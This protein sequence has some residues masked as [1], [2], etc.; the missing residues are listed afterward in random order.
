MCPLL[1]L[2]DIGKIFYNLSNFI[3]LPL[4]LRQALILLSTLSRHM[5]NV[6]LSLFF[7]NWKISDLVYYPNTFNY[8]N[9]FF[10]SSTVHLTPDN[11]LKPV[12]HLETLDL[13]IQYGHFW[14]SDQYFIS[15]SNMGSFDFQTNA[16]SLNSSFSYMIPR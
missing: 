16:W 13:A 4:V 2:H 6:C 11:D 1:V 8:A 15:L 9:L 7:S 12:F 5:F 10:F 14:F 3:S